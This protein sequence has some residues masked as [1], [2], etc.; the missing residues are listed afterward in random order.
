MTTCLFCTRPIT[1]NTFMLVPNFEKPSEPRF[2]HV[3]E[4]ERGNATNYRYSCWVRSR[5]GTIS[6]D[7]YFAAP[8]EGET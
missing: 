5:H 2:C 7:E 6:L 4:D 1:Q 8:Y 3:L